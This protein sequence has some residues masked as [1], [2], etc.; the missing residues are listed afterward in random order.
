MA[1]EK[2]TP[3]KTSLTP[4]QAGTPSQWYAASIR[5]REQVR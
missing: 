1:D 5:A 4:E 2:Q 3:P